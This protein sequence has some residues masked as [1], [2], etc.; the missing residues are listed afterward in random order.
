M[1]SM[2]EVVGKERLHIQGHRIVL[3]DLLGPHVVLDMHSTRLV[4]K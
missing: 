4:M 2:Q 3:Q 1:Y